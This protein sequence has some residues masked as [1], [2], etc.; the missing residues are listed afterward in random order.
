[1]LF[2]YYQ[3]RRGGV[4]GSVACR[5]TRC[6]CLVRIG[7]HVMF[8]SFDSMLTRPPPALWHV[9]LRHVLLPVLRLRQAVL[10]L[11]HLIMVVL[12]LLLIMVVLVLL[13]VVVI[14]LLPSHDDDD[15]TVTHD[16]FLLLILLLFLLL[17]VLSLFCC[18][19]SSSCYS[20]R[21]PRPPA[22]PTP[23][24]R[25]CP[26]VSVQGWRRM[27]GSTAVRLP[28]R[29]WLT[30]VAGGVGQIDPGDGLLGG[31]CHTCI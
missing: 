3:R 5:M 25:P 27:L 23:P 19:S 13:L 11:L 9:L 31:Q 28:V 24:P 14:F 15:K 6:P 16:L 18:Y 17:L 21:P 20:S 26:P 7:K 4:G 12:I 2:V 22:T 8:C 1:M 29:Q 10:L 30:A